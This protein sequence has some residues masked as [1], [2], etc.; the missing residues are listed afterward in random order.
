MIRGAIAALA[1]LCWLVAT[2]VSAKPDDLRDFVIWSL[3]AGDQ[4]VPLVIL[5]EGTGGTRPNN[6][7]VW[8]E[9]LNARGVA[10][11]QVRSAATRGRNDWSGTSCGLQYSGD[12][13][14]ALD[15]ARITQPRV[16]TTRFAV[17]GF[18]RG[19]TEVL[20]SAKSFNGAPAAPTAVFAFY[21]GCEGWCSTDYS[22]NG[23]T[24]VNIL[25][26]DADDWG[27]YRDSYGQCRRLAGGK[28]TFHSLPGAHHG[29][30]NRYTGT[31]NVA[32]K[33]F[34]YQPNAEATETARAIVWQA[35]APPW[36]L[37][38]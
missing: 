25:Y 8:A 36:G 9:W 22:K 28:I 16:D 1:T 29:F 21:P 23:P 11:A 14:D 30:D 15:L 6:R 31:F 33:V 32:G 19:G 34:R 5:I 13:R 17:M 3:P 20:N 24:A 37:P 7:S 2:P 38:N 18:S 26:G 35:L 4:K 10:V 27:Q 12:A